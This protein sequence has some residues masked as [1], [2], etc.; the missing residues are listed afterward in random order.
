MDTAGSRPL[1]SPAGPLRNRAGVG[2]GYGVWVI[3]DRRNMR[4][5]LS[6]IVAA[7]L[8]PAV[9]SVNS[10]NQ[11]GTHTG[12]LSSTFKDSIEVVDVPVVVR[13]VTGRSVPN[14]QEHQFQLFD[15]GRVQRIRRF[16][17]NT[18][19]LRAAE[20]SSA[21]KPD[22]FVAYLFDDLRLP[23]A[24]LQLTRD[25]LSRQL[26][27]MDGTVDRVAI[28][29]TSG[30]VM[31]DFTQ[32]PAK[33]AAALHN[34][35][36]RR[37]DWSQ[38]RISLDV[39]RRTVERL[40]ALPGQ[41]TLVLASPGFLTREVAL[42]FGG[43]MV[44][45]D[46][47]Q[48]VSAIVDRAVRS[49]VVISCLDSRGVYADGNGRLADFN[50]DLQRS[51]SEVL[52]ELAHGTGGSLFENNNDMD[53]GLREVAARPEFSYILGFSPDNLKHDGGYHVIKVV[54]KSSGYLD[55]HARHGYSAP[56]R[57]R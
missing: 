39:L 7:I 37:D 47:K 4:L 9:R 16:V 38:G 13:D 20:Q 19:A 28:F 53:R 14:L 27:P 46:L 12:E 22:R 26:Q 32:D 11:V 50:S 31:Q 52:A 34:I 36:L 42:P 8:A 15:N 51:M 48:E 43:K 54:L 41:R 44:G 3:G 23:T 2:A 40:S 33:L 55:V 30:Q 45:I 21:P 57:Y 5:I 24:Q 18:S 10:Q 25:A 56:A 6:V 49:D 29:C 17:A 35:R 1:E